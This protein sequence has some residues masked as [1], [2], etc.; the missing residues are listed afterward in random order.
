MKISTSLFSGR[1]HRLER[2]TSFSFT[3]LSIANFISLA[4]KY[5]HETEELF[6]EK[7]FPAL[8]SP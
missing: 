2:S 5:L 7:V 3:V 4:E 6:E 1:E 8:I